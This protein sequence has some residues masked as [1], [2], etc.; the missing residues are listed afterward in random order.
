MEQF[1][2]VLIEASSSFSWWHWLLGLGVAVLFQD[3][4]GKELHI[5]RQDLTLL[6]QKQEEL[7][8]DKETIS[9]IPLLQ[10]QFPFQNHQ[11][12]QQPLI[13]TANAT[14]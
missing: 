14:N 10:K 8:K 6:L 11:I 4:L 9:Q 13:L 12:E 2:Q 7:K 1:I 3:N 5:N